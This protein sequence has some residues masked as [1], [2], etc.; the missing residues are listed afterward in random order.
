MLIDIMIARGRDDD[1]VELLARQGLV[2]RMDR[3]AAITT[4]VIAFL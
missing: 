3:S 1:E 4:T 2:R